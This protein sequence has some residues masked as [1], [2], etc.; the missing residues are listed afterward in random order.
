MEINQEVVKNALEIWADLP[1][2]LHGEP[3]MPCNGSEGAAFINRWCQSCQHDVNENCQI[4]TLMLSGEQQKEWVFF[5]NK[6]IC[7]SYKKRC[8]ERPRNMVKNQKVG[9]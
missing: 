5:E 7:T 8:E 3:Y 4:L 2:T 6:P 1:N 9:K